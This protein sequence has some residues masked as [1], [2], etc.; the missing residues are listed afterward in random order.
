MSEWRLK[1]F[2]VGY[3]AVWFFGLWIGGYSSPSAPNGLGILFF[4]AC[5]FG[6]L[7]III[8]AAVLWVL[9]ML[10]VVAH[11]PWTL[12]RKLNDRP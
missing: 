6:T 11:L 1:L 9:K 10:G 8:P 4:G 3:L 7:A 2:A 12:D 5:I